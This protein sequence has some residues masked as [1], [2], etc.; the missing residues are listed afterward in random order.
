[1]TDIGKPK[2]KINV[3]P[4]PIREPASP[5]RAD[6]KRSDQPASEPERSG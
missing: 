2:R 5:K 3:E 4:E 1:M 6:P